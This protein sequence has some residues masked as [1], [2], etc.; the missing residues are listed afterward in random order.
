MRAPAAARVARAPAAARM[1]A[2]VGSGLAVAAHRKDAQ[3][4]SV[5]FGSYIAFS[6][7]ISATSGHTI[8]NWYLSQLR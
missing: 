4:L 2:A 8:L 5:P 7:M 3:E 6:A 1:A